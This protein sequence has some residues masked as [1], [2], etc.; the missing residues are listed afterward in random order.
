MFKF[1]ATG[2]VHY[3]IQLPKLVF[4]YS[5]T[6]NLKKVEAAS[7]RLIS[8]TQVKND[9][10]KNGFTKEDMNERKQYFYE[11]NYFFLNF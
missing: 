6:E 10:N 1:Q 3:T 4:S 11:G 5:N 7:I 8:M 9:V 2:Y